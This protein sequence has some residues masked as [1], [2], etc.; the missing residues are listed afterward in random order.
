[1]NSLV[2]STILNETKTHL[3]VR[4]NRLPANP[5]SILLVDA[6][7]LYG[8]VISGASGQVQWGGTET[9]LSEET[10]PDK[11]IIAKDFGNAVRI[12]EGLRTINESE[13]INFT[14]AGFSLAEDTDVKSYL[15]RYVNWQSTVTEIAISVE[16][17]LPHGDVE[18]IQQLF[19]RLE[20]ENESEPDSWSAFDELE[21][22]VKLFGVK[23]IDL[24]SKLIEKASSY[25]NAFIA[26]DILGAMNHRPTY[27]ARLSLALDT[28]S[29]NHPSVRHG[30][31]N[32]LGSLKSMDAIAPL[33][34]LIET[35]YSSLNRTVAGRVL[36][37]I[38]STT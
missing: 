14:G 28:L 5:E 7:G 11:L 17:S 38:K 32:A 36:E 15:S 12:D 2:Q 6:E 3:A 9:G 22:A 8:L 13:A 35:D 27:H 37:I 25:A 33:Q 24:L 30:A 20:D 23:T 10:K 1:M 21:K 19:L 16:V 4:A 26:L 34:N 29:H 18:K 31:I